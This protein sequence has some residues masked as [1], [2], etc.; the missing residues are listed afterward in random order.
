MYGLEDKL[1]KLPDRPG[2][3]IMKDK[4]ENIIY[5][6]K[7]ISLRNRVRQYFQDSKHKDL[8]VKVMVSHIDD[9]EYIIVDNEVEALIL[10]A[11]LIKKHK[12][13]Y[14]ILLRDDK[15][16]PYIKVTIQERFPRVLKTRLVE[17]DGA[18]YF[19]PYPNVSSVDNA[20]EI[21]RDLYP[22]RNCNRNLEKGYSRRRPC[23]NLFIKRCIGPCTGKVSDDEYGNMIKE[24]LMF[25][26]GKEEL[27]LSI[28]EDKMFDASKELR[29]ED[30]AKYRDQI[31]SLKHLWEKQK[32]IS[33]KNPTDQDIIAAAKGIEETSI[34]VFFVRKGKIIG[35]EHFII[36]NSFNEDI[37][38]ILNS[39]L[40]QFYSGTAFI[41]K[42]IVIESNID[43]RQAIEKWL[44]L[45]KGSKVSI[46]VPKIGEKK[47]LVE[48]VKENARDMINKYGDKFVRQARQKQVA[49]VDLKEMLYLNNNIDRIEAYDISN[50]SGSNSVAS[51]VVFEKGQAKKSDYRRFRIKTVSKSDDYASMEEVLTRRFTRGLQEREKLEKENVE[52]RAFSK[53]PDLIMVDGGKG[54]VNRA[55]SV[56]YKLGIDIPVCGLVK[57][58]FHNTRGIIYNNEEINMDKDSEVFKLI[59]EIQEEA[60]RFAISYHRS[61]R[62]K[63]MLKSELDGI[64]EIGPKRKKDLL[65]HFKSIDKIKNAS[66]EELLEVKSMNKSASES[67]IN[68]FKK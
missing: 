43:D 9:F 56:M 8:K 22:I 18:K 17:K 59:Y 34:Q 63:D 42:E 64:P 35:R 52:F 19:G 49:L 14:N 1:K 15:Q 47:K 3:Y 66:V 48:M 20:I 4:S 7:A 31:E 27:L 5:V 38:S 13:K 23:L 32:I 61:L 40:K 12:P 51:M 67:L 26:G 57:D 29:F 39:F 2:V 16:Y 65:K 68:Y 53:F 55:L 44:S 10:E 28:I 41:P 50:I 24:I 46:I 37:K 54:Q 21:I 6:G 11:N 30:A 58:D 62:S 60:H 33:T 25:L 45:S 36:E